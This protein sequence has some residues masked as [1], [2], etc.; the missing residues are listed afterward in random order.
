M[1][2]LNRIALVITPKQPMCDWIASFDDA[3]PTLAE[4]QQE[5]SS[6]LIDEPEQEQPLDQ[7]LEQLISEHYQNISRNEFAVWDEYLDHAPTHFDQAQFCQW[8]SVQLSGLT[9]D[10]AK[11]QLMSADVDNT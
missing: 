11:Q 4:L 7:L 9:F 8:F 2:F 3:A 10:L 6:Y 5:S 1:K